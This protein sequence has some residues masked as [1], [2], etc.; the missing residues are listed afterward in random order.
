MPPSR[1]SRFGDD[2]AAGLR[3]EQ[4]G[5]EDLDV[6]A[7]VLGPPPHR[8]EVAPRRHR[9]EDPAA[10]V[11]QGDGACAAEA[12]G[13]DDEAGSALELQASRFRTSKEPSTLDL[14]GQ[15]KVTSMI[16]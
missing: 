4:V 11:R 5:D 14:L 6:V 1:S 7:G 10:K 8:L 12:A 2:V 13:A 15:M 3:V 16:R 9:R